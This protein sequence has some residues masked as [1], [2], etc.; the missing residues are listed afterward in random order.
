M[1]NCTGDEVAR[2]VHAIRIGASAAR[3]QIEGAS[4][5]SRTNVSGKLFIAIR[6]RNADGHTF[7]EEVIRKG[8]PIS[9]VDSRF[10]ADDTSLNSHLVVVEDTMRALHDLARWWLDT[11]DATKIAVTGTNGKTTTKEM[12]ADVLATTF[13][14][15]R[16]QGNLN[17]QYG[18]P[19]SIFEMGGACQCAVFEFGMSTPGEIANLTKLVRP[20]YGVITNIEAAHLETMMSVDAIAAAKYELF[21]N[22]PSDGVAIANID[23]EKLDAR[24]KVEKLRTFPFGLRNRSGF[25]PTDYVVNG[26]GCA[27]FTI[28]GEGQIRLAVPGIHNLYNAVAAAAVG[29]LFGIPG[30]NIKAALEAFRAVSM[31]METI[32]VAGVTIINDSYNA[33]PASMRFAMDTLNAMKASGTARRIAV[34]G[35]MLELGSSASQYHRDIGEYAAK[36]TLDFLATSGKLAEQIDAGAARSGFPDANHRHFTSTSAIINFL[37]DMLKP[38]DIVLI[39]AS[40][41]MAF[42]RITTALRAQLGRAN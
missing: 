18:I 37:L 20:Q 12:I 8:S 1:I 36:N 3:Q 35:D 9:I 10:H 13:K 4:I 19:L 31:R 42:D 33:N 38:G 23:N 24:M 17:N 41:G 6:G 34:L 40:R 5:D 21:D 29:E 30:E 14:T 7:V 2:A 32:D 27:R 16:S 11:F 28:K 26:S 39:K 15:F 25:A 22:M